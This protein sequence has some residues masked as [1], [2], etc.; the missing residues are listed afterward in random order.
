M[1]TILCLLTT[2]VTIATSFSAQA[3]DSLRQSVMGSWKLTAVYDQFEDGTRR[4]TWGTGAQGLVIFTSEG[5]FSAIIVGSDRQPKAGTVPTDPVGPAIAYYG[6]YT[7]DEAA[8]TFTTSV[9]Q[10]TFPQWQG[11]ALTRHVDELTDTRLAVTAAPVTGPDGRKFV[12]HLE[13]DRVK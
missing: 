7:I 6:T 10:S 8:H 2:V 9:L 1:R 13:F 12:P 5:L 4:N 11:L 3:A